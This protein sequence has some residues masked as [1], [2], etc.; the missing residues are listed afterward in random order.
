MVHEERATL[1]HRGKNKYTFLL[2]R[3]SGK[4]ETQAAYG[5]LANDR[6]LAINKLKELH[7]ELQDGESSYEVGLAVSG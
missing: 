3:Y 4:E 7:Q 5:S 6:N 1:R 2:N